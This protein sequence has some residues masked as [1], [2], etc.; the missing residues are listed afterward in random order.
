[1]IRYAIRYK[2]CKL[3]ALKKADVKQHY[4]LHET[5][6]KKQKERIKNNNSGFGFLRTLTP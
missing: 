5:K 3:L 6:N 2:L 1:M 4:L